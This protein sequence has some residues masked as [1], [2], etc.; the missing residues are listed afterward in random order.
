MQVVFSRLAPVAWT[1]FT[2]GSLGN[3]SS[4]WFQCWFYDTLLKNTLILKRR[5]NLC[6]VFLNLSATYWH[7]MPLFLEFYVSMEAIF[8]MQF[9]NF[10]VVPFTS[11]FHSNVFLTFWLPSRQFCWFL[12]SG[13]IEKSTEMAAVR[14]SW[15]NFHAIR[16]SFP[17]WRPQRKHV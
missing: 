9:L 7:G 2:F 15:Q 1:S 4:L 13:E 5:K 14:K 10:F 12:S 17:F 3:L 11:L 8:L 16:L 6:D